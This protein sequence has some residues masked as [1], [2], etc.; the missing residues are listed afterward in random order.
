MYIFFLIILLLSHI[1]AILI[2]TFEINYNVKVYFEFYNFFFVAVS[3]FN[4]KWRTL[5]LSFEHILRFK[6]KNNI[7]Y[8]SHSS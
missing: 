8:Y 5:S 3:F 6:I 4:F 2:T 1:V 7:E